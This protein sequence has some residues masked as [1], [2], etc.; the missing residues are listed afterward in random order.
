MLNKQKKKAVIILVDDNNINLTIGQKVLAENYIVVT[1]SSAEKMFCILENIIPDMILLDI[2]M[3]E[4][5]GYEAIKNLK[6]KQQTKDI[7][8]IFLT[9]R[10]DTS[11]EEN[12][13][14]LGAIDYIVKPYQRD[15]LYKR[16]ETGLKRYKA[17]PKVRSF[18]YHSVSSG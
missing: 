10:T 9:G 3:P 13:L 2:E 12:G 5:D 14:S 1:A 16:I 7:P 15:S 6:S 11:D 4:M 8:V 18:L 17:T